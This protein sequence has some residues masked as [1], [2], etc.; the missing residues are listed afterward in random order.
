M[1]FTLLI[2]GRIDA[3]CLLRNVENFKSSPVVVSTWEGQNLPALYGSVI[4]VKNKMPDFHGIQNFM[5]QLISTLEGLKTV[6]TEYVIKVRGDEFFNYTKLMKK[7]ESKRDVIF[8]IP[9]FFRSFDFWPYH[10]SDHMMAGRTDYMRSM[11]SVAKLKYET[12]LSHDD[13][14]EWG[15]TK[16]HMANMGFEKFEDYELGKA[17]M[18]RLFDIADLN[19]LKDYRIT[20]NSH[21]SKFYNNFVPSHWGSIEDIKSL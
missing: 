18:K 19:E 20:I 10:I 15:L 6:E 17:E 16:A 14:K 7:V 9:V 3:E 8:S 13:C 11:F 5:L 12:T 4:V 1:N 2:Q 21:G